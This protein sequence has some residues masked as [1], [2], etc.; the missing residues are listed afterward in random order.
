MKQLT[1]KQQEILDFL[2]E[3]IRE[4]RYTPTVREIAE[5][6]GIKSTNAVRD[7][8]AAL[9]RKGC[10]TRRANTSRG[11]EL[12][13]EYLEK[14]EGIPIV[15]RVAAG[16][17]VTAVENLDGYLAFETLFGGNDKLYAL[18]VEGDSMIDDGIWDGDYVIVHEQPSLDNGE[19]GVAIIDE[20]AT[21]KRIHRRGKIIELIPANELYQPMEIDPEETP[22]RIGG[23]VIGVHRRLR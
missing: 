14:P 15:G 11:I 23:K 20:E 7:H 6:F 5:R 9:E 18:R 10:L 17:P 2:I 19:I 22:F 12:A 8:L 16:L 13:E 3:C 21:V 1:E 4:E